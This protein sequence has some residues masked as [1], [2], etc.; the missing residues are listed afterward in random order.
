MLTTRNNQI[1]VTELKRLLHMLK[2]ARPDIRLRFRLAGEMWQS[3]HLR[4]IDVSE[5]GA[6]L[7]DEHLNKLIYIR[8]LNKVMQFELE[9]AFQQYQPHFHY[10]VRPIGNT[11]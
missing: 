9:E 8:D 2:D 5:N 6:V 4:L 11:P 1:P 7:N 3:N 10:S